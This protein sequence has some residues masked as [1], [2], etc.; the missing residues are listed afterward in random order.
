MAPRFGEAA[1]ARFAAS[2]DARIAVK[3]LRIG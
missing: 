2:S 1:D 3:E